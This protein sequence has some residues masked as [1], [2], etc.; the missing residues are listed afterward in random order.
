MNIFIYNLIR[1]GGFGYM[2]ILGKSEKR[3]IYKYKYN[4]F[5]V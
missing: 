5:I 2:F 1:I 3:K 4:I